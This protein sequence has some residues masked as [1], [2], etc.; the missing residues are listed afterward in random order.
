MQLQTKRLLIREYSQGDAKHLLKLVS[1]PKTTPYSDWYLNTLGEVECFIDNAIERQNDNPRGYFSFAIEAQDSGVYM[2]H[3][4]LRCDDDL[5]NAETGRTIIMP[6]RNKGYATEA[7]EAI[8][9]FAFNT[10]RLERVFA[11]LHKDNVESIASLTKLGFVYE[12]DTNLSDR[13]IYSVPA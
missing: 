2:G 5:K 9:D 7:L 12:R 11:T 6:E 3:I 10:L 1:N 8:L 13:V 4:S